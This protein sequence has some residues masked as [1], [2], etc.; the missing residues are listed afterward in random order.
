MNMNELIEIRKELDRILEWIEVTTE[1][2]QWVL[3]ANLPF[4][5]R[6]L[7][8]SAIT[9]AVDDRT[10][11]ARCNLTLPGPLHQYLLLNY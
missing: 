6:H 4:S 11:L 1:S 7:A 9:R 10:R 5:L 8:R 2:V 3:K